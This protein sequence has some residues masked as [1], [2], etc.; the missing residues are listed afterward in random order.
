MPDYPAN[1]STISLLLI[2]IL[3]AM[4]VASLFWFAAKVRREGFQLGAASKDTEIAQLR[5]QLVDVARNEEVAARVASEQAQVLLQLRESLLHA[6]GEQA[7]LSGKLESL[8]QIEAQLHA[9]QELTEHLRQRILT[10]ETKLAET[11]AR[12]S[13]QQRSFIEQKS[14]LE[15]AENR[16]RESFNALA[17]QIFEERSRQFGEQSREQLSHLLNPLKE[18]IKTFEERIGQTWSSDQRERGMLA[19]ELQSLK[20]LNQQMTT[21]AVNLTR[22]LKGDTRVQGGWGEMLLERVLEAS[23]LM[24]G[25]DYDLQVHHAD[26]EGGRARPDA[27]IHLPE[28]K[29]VVLD[30]KVSLTAFAAF[31]ESNE[32]ESRKLLLNEHLASLRRHIDGLSRRDYASLPDI[33]TID[34]VL[35]FVPIEAAFIDAVR[36]DDTLYRYAQ[37][38]NI[39]IVGPSTLLATLRTIAYLWKL[40]TRTRNADEIAKLAGGLYDQFVILEQEFTS[41]G[42]HIKRALDLHETASRRISTGNGNLMRRVEKLRKLGADAKK[43]LPLEKFDED[44]SNL[45]EIE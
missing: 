26:G 21:E 23:G 41:V 32:I 28:N 9:S 2:C 1:L 15:A 33:K 20:I 42:T 24:R 17:G 30:A 4:L 19:Q 14:Q 44:N 25:R 11:Q 38:R 12:S 16:L 45:D 7:R 31:V 35:M 18:Q 13:E 8:D 34:F 36:A 39:I 6:H 40:E 37:D 5:Q 29:D 22:A 27:I 10:S 3:A 43:Q